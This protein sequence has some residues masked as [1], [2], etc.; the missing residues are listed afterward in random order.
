MSL[1]NYPCSE[2]HKLFSRSDSLARHKRSHHHMMDSEVEVKRRRLSLDEPETGS[3][4][5][6]NRDIFDDEENESEMDKSENDTNTDT[7]EE[8]DESDTE[9]NDD[10]EEEMDEKLP[11]KDI[12]TFKA[13]F[14]D[15]KEAYYEELGEEI[16]R[17]MNDGLS[18]R[19]AYNEAMNI[20]IWIHKHTC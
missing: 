5:G 2:C 9:E 4:D 19:K 10:T 8:I 17:L 20:H 16:K 14:D 13:L 3:I 15:Q 12:E 7:G 11:Q 6:I 18:D 1:K